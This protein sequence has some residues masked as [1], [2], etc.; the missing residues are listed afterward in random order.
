MKEVKELSNGVVVTKCYIIETKFAIYNAWEPSSLS[1]KH[2]TVTTINDKW[3]GKIGTDPDPDKFK[4]L[5]VGDERY[6]A[7]HAAYEERRQLAEKYIH[8]AFPE[9]IG[10]VINSYSEIEVNE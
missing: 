4:H 5:P 2:G 6:E 7:V 3:Y 1:G 9:T 10:K 8:E